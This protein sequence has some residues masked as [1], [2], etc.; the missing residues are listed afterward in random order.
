MNTDYGIQTFS[1]VDDL[2]AKKKSILLITPTIGEIVQSYQ[3]YKEL[4]KLF[5]NSPIYTVVD[6][7]GAYSVA[8]NINEISKLFVYSNDTNNKAEK[9]LKSTNPLMVIFVE[10]CY[11]PYLV[12]E[13][14][15]MNIITLLVSAAMNEAIQNHP[16]YKECFH[17][18]AYK[19]F[20]YVGIKSSRYLKDF[21]AL[22]VSKKKLF[23]AGDLKMDYDR[24][25]LSYNERG[26]Y[27]ELMGL[28][29]KDIFIAGSI[30]R[31]ECKIVIDTCRRLLSAKD[32]IKCI[33]A[34][35]FTDNIKDLKNYARE[36]AI[37]V[38]TKSE[39]IGGLFDKD[40]ADVILIDTYGE[41]GKI[42]GLGDVIFVGGTLRPFADKP[43]GQN[44]LEPLFHGKPI[45][46][47]PNVKKDF[48]VIE[49]LQK[50]I[51]DIIVKNPDELFNRISFLLLNKDFRK[52]YS[53][54][55]RD[56]VKFNSNILA[57]SDKLTE[58]R[59]MIRNDKKT[60]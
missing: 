1:V 53:L 23:I 51:P 14:Q 4:R 2:N 49:K 27:E 10:N 56:S 41:L 15:K 19:M 21:L 5:N 48:D 32:N 13:A 3:L 22:G 43:M 31:E 7:E 59:D 52:N 34:P 24:L 25:Y 16:R 38:A 33:V 50:F 12:I 8:K 57:L 20:S 39:L 35:R 47:G 18:D 28:K 54:F 17:L 30:S 29:G 36:A 26:E 55:I 58:V 46:V 45:V 42:Y 11:Y 37:S 44:I 9:L 60:Q 40:S 6:D